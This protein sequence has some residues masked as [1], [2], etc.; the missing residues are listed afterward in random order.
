[1]SKRSGSRRELKNINNIPAKEF[2]KH[3]YY[4]INISISDADYS[5]SSDR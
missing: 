1:M 4:I 3:Y 2:K 5:L